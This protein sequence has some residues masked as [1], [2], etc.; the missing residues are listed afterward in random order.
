MA[1]LPHP[2]RPHTLCDGRNITVDFSRAVPAPCMKHRPGYFC[3]ERTYFNYLSDFLSGCCARRPEFALEAFPRDHLRDLF[4][5]FGAKCAGE[6]P[7]GQI[8]HDSVVLFVT[9]ERGE[10]N[11]LYHSMTDF[12]NAFISLEMLRVRPQ[13]VQVILLDAHGVGR[14][15]EVWTKVFSKRGPVLRAGDLKA[16]SAVVRYSHA[17]FSPPG[18]TSILLSEL[19][20]RNTR[21]DISSQLLQAFAHHMLVNL[22]IIED[23]LPRKRSKLAGSKLL[24]AMISRKAYA[25]RRVSRVMA[26]EA[27]VFR[28]VQAHPLVLGANATL[29][30]LSELSFSNQLRL[31]SQVDVLVGMHG[32][33]LTHL[34]WLRPGAG[35]L[36]LRPSPSLGWYSYA[37]MAKWMGL[38]FRAWES[39]YEQPGD[40]HV[41]VS[42]VSAAFGEVAAA[43]IQT[44]H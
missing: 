7:R 2:T 27:E 8:Q 31:M 9:R 21:C 18:Y 32:A 44:L 22:G 19:R 43:V 26:N 30:E 37:H 29:V 41:D 11:N 10:H 17:I 33:G 38:H 15:D 39:R 3:G 42:A 40:V 25:G 4:E 12:L 13:D 24:V 1:W 5:S 16:D 23:V 34:L 28:A 14:Y 35:V 6:Q 36:E 20:E